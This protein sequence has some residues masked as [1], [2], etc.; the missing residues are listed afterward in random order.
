M[1]SPNDSIANLLVTRKSLHASGPRTP[2]ARNLRRPFPAPFARPLTGKWGTKIKKPA[3]E[4][5]GTSSNK[6]AGAWKS[7]EWAQ[8]IFSR[9]D[10]RREDRLMNYFWMLA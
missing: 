4:S 6:K 1:S 2:L 9:R 3:L 5:A 10:R 7:A 8:R